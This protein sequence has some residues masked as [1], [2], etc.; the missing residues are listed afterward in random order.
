MSEIVLTVVRSFFDLNQ[1]LVQFI[2]G[3]VFFVLGL[4]VALQSRHRSRLALARSLGWLAIFGLA[5]GLYE[6]A[7]LFIPLQAS[8]MNHASVALLQLYAALLLAVS[9]AALLQFGASLLRSR[10]PR[11]QWLALFLI[12]LW[13]AGGLYLGLTGNTGIGL[14]EIRASIWARYLLGFSGAMLT[15]F[16][17]REQARQQ[18]GPL[19]LTGIYNTVRLAGLAFAVYAVLS[20]LIG[21]YADFFPARWLNQSLLVRWLGVPVAVF[22][23]L[24]G[25][26]ITV[27]I[28]RAMEVFDVETDQLIEAMELEQ[29]LA[30]ERERI[31]RELHDG[32][33]QQVYTAGLI[34]ESTRGKVPAESLVGQRL[35]R[36]I[37]ALNEAIASLR[38]YMTDL[39]SSG[40]QITLVQGLHERAADPTLAAL[41]EVRLELD[42]PDDLELNPAQT[43]HLLAIVGEALANVARHAAAN[44]VI[45]RA[46]RQN[47]HL[48]LQIQD[49]GVG[50]RSDA[51]G[52]GFGLRNMRDRA[53][54]LGGE[55]SLKSAPGQGTTV[56]V[57]TPWKTS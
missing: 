16:G 45:L 41:L 4:A 48:V 10:W 1:E 9:F 12:F 28:I 7:Q 11:L 24:A 37:I 23:S 20:G 25:L 36:A 17:L 3:L 14:W 30:A 35:D 52:D 43:T 44:Q 13:P 50:F 40:P 51:Q 55:L 34:L 42:L 39:R 21:P 8:Y 31:G 27:S 6:W 26:V 32:A 22:R 46:T 15:A 5:H 57:S 38:A 49:D 19:N 54:M 53:R 47:G 2:Y 56:S 18:I 29:N 33:I